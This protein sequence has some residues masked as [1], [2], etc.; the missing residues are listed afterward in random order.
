MIILGGAGGKII[1]EDL[2]IS[3]QA[4]IEDRRCLYDLFLL[5][6]LQVLLGVAQ[7]SEHLL[8]VLSQ[9]GRMAIYLSFRL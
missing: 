3:G 9:Q 2:Q 8:C 6:P 7:L 4:S 1:V 5:Q